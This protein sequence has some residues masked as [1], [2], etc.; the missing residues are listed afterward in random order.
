MESGKRLLNVDPTSQHGPVTLPSMTPS[1]MAMKEQTRGA[2][3]GRKGGI[4]TTARKRS[5]R[6]GSQQVRGG[7]VK[8]KSA[9]SGSHDVLSS[10]LKSDD[11][12]ALEAVLLQLS[13]GNY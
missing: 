1:L 9:P 5:S 7:N 11:L 3:G 13:T 10:H 12:K 2:G 8:T 6:V 4:A